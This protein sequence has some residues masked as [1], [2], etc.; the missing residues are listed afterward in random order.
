[1]SLQCPSHHP[2]LVLER[3]NNCLLNKL[4]LHSVRHFVNE[5]LEVLGGFKISDEHQRC[6]AG[7]W[8]YSKGTMKGNRS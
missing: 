6:C 2:D 8:Q 5:V 7:N 4:H 1:M 3:F